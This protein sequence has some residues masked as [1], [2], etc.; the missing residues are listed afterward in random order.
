MWWAFMKS[1]IA[2]FISFSVTITYSSMGS[3]QSSKVMAPGSK[4][5]DVPSESVGRE[6]RS[7]TLPVLTNSCITA[8]FFG[9]QP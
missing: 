9:W 5:P 6:A 2:Y 3:R 8:E 4:L 1:F 7:R